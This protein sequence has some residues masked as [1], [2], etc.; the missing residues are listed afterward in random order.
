MSAIRSITGSGLLADAPRLLRVAL[1]LDA[2]VTGVNGLAYLALAGPL[3]SLLGLD[4]AHSRA[5]GAFLVVYALAVWAVS[6]PAA[7][8]RV[9]ASAV[10]EA[11]VVWAVL[12][13]VAVATGWLS[14]TVAGGVWAVMQALVVVGF[15]A[16]QYTALRHNR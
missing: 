14:L 4:T 3:E 6:M 12:S 15:A 11:N 13:I 9:A 10:M 5:I 1:R 2:V 8:S 7:I 16:V